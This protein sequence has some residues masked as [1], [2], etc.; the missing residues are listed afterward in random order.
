MATV[1]GCWGK[2]LSSHCTMI[3]L[4]Q[5]FVLELLA[6]LSEARIPSIVFGIRGSVVGLV[7]WLLYYCNISGS[8]R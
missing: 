5:I 3:L 6:W 2:E 8:S 7:G 4:R 1:D